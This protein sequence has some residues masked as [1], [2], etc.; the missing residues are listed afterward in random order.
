M[1]IKE[2]IA[3]SL[4]TKKKAINQRITLKPHKKYV[5]KSMLVQGKIQLDRIMA[6]EVMPPFT[7]EKGTINKAF[8][9][10]VKAPPNNKRRIFLVFC[11]VCGFIF[12]ILSGIRPFYEQRTQHSTKWEKSSY[13]IGY[14]RIFSVTRFR[15]ISRHL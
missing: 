6:T 4:L 5:V 11:L 9:K 13:F 1:P 3:N 12:L 8:A 7:I 2:E 10:P 15:K 14:I